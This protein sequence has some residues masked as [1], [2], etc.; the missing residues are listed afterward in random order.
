[1]DILL[2]EILTFLPVSSFLIK[3]LQKTLQ[4]LT[5]YLL[6]LN[7]KSSYANESPRCV[8]N[9]KYSNG[10]YSWT[11]SLK[12]FLFTSISHSWIHPKRWAFQ[13]LCTKHPN[14]SCLRLTPQI[15]R[16]LWTPALLRFSITSCGRD[17]ALG[18]KLSNNSQKIPYLL[19]LWKPTTL[20]Y[21]AGELSIWMY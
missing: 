9:L 3:I 2:L 8:W 18:H 11:F 14:P 17:L 21:L 6:V 16:Q 1:M 20:T 15:A 7:E 13:P 10:C 12:S 19:P 4:F 5:Y